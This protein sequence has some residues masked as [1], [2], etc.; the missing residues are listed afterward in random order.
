MYI[1]HDNVV[2]SDSYNSGHIL[3]CSCKSLKFCTKWY[4]KLCILVDPF[5]RNCV[6]K[7]NFR[8]FLKKSPKKALAL[9]GLKALMKSSIQFLIKEVVLY[10]FCFLYQLDHFALTKKFGDSCLQYHVVPVTGTNLLLLY[11]NDQCES[12]D[13]SDSSCTCTEPTDG[14]SETK[15][16]TSLLWMVM[17]T[18]LFLLE[19]RNFGRG[20][21]FFFSASDVLIDV[22]NIISLNKKN[23]LGI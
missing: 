8:Y 4:T 14:V 17:C 13:G 10:F 2:T 18:T 12:L 22:L 5:L 1:R 3:T 23:I 16:Y 7:L 11:I 20:W 21:M 6:T 15:V 9:K 19:H